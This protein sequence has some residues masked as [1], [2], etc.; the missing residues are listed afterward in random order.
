MLRRVV[1]SSCRKKRKKPWRS[2]STRHNDPAD[3][4]ERGEEEGE[5]EGVE[6]LAR[7]GG[8]NEVEDWMERDW[9]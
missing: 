9:A 4:L 8:R 2:V 6:V 1:D 5:E 7:V 3:T